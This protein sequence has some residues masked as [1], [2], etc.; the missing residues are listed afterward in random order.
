VADLSFDIFW[1]VIPSLALFLVLP[2]LLRA[3]WNFWAALGLSVVVTV[4]LYLA[5]LWALTQFGIK[6]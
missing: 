4:T 2:P 5:E 6:K 3:G 1:L